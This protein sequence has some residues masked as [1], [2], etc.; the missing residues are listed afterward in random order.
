[1]PP[2][3]LTGYTD[4]LSYRPGAPVE[5]FVSLPHHGAV[6]VELIRPNR[7]IGSVRDGQSDPVVAWPAAGRYPAGPQDSCVGSFMVGA[8]RAAPAG[9]LSFG[10][11]LWLAAIDD[12][13]PATVAEF[14]AGDLFV[15]IELRAGRAVLHGRAAGGQ[16]WALADPV[17]LQPLC[18]YLI[19]GVVDGEQAALTVID[20]RRSTTRAVRASV[21]PGAVPATRSVTYAGSR[22]R[23]V[24]QAG[25]VVRGRVT[26]SLTGK[27]GA[28]FVTGDAV[29]TAELAQLAVGARPR[30]LLAGR[31][32]GA[33]SLAVAG[34]P[35]HHRA[36]A[37][38][39]GIEPALLVNGPA[40]GVTGARWTGRVT[41]YALAPDEYE[42]AHFHAT[43][44]V[45]AGWSA[46]LAARLPES[47]PSG[48][49][50]LR[51]SGDGATD[52][53]PIVVLP[54]PAS[55]PDVLLL[56]PTFS[57]LAYGNE[58]LFEIV[59]GALAAGVPYELASADILHADR[60]FGRSLYDTHP[61]GS[62]VMLSAAAR[63]IVNM[64]PDYTMWQVRAGRG[65]SGDM[66]LIEWLDR[67]GIGYDVITDLELHQGGSA[68]LTGYA[69]VLTGA[70]PEYYS[71]RMLDALTRYRD[72]GGGLMYLGGN[73]FY[74]PTEVLSA[75]PLVVEV[76]RG[77][78]GVRAWESAPG[79]VTLVSDHAPGGLWRHRGRPPQQLC[80]VGFAAQGWDR[81]SPYRRTEQSYDQAVSWIF[82]GVQEDP[83]GDY[84]RVLGGA[85]GDEL[86][87]AD[88]ALGTPP[89]AVVLA[90]SFGH[91]GYYQRSV[92]EVPALTRG[93]HGGDTDPEVRADMVFVPAG[94]GGVFSVGS[95]AWSG[96]L[97]HND[98]VNGVSRITRN[99]LDRFRSAA[100]R[101]EIPV[102]F[103]YVDSRWGQLH[104]A[105]AG[106]GPPLLL[107]HQVPRSW[108]EFRE[109]I[110][111]LAGRYRV[112]AMDML[113]FGASAAGPAGRGIEDLAAAS[114]GLMDALGIGSFAVLGHH[115]GG[116][117]AIEMA[118]A[119]PE[120]VSALIVSST[121]WTDADYRRRNA[122]GPG[123][124]DAERSPDGAHLTHWWAQRRPH[125][126]PDMPYLL[127]RLVRDA[128]APGVD[129]AVAHGMAAAYRMEDRITAVTAP[130]LL[131]GAAADEHTIG[132]QEVLRQRLIA[133]SS[134][135]S[136][137]IDGGTVP[138]MEQCP[139][140]VAAAV[141]AFLTPE[142]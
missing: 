93:Q 7:A 129:P 138:L 127:D 70:H 135:D 113:G 47:L 63:P 84:G 19:A 85:A 8:L 48:L 132:D 81:S 74:W 69:A 131:I 54:Q 141:S 106:A 125:Y 87:R 17:V 11:F 115:T 109:I 89:E 90:S 104:Y 16:V 10:Q 77:H 134:V 99:V 26:N 34:A 111:L 92:E 107:L 23:D 128:L 114:A 31:L 76:R 46:T 112:I 136:V 96:A 61:D 71:E 124:D 14:A 22:P 62:G 118:A 12:Q 30:D 80:G 24:E 64:R 33:W 66:Y 126:P 102:R 51:V 137:V 29:R 119:H 43:D 50:G 117:V 28:P 95:I 110:P 35:D 142:G 75:D 59:D 27:L 94:R 15:G 98:S 37:E 120:R 56:L 58:S 49:Y 103:G 122:D 101:P 36:A 53:I 13:G 3:A 6:D 82:D 38:A 133:A 1:M 105:E 41:D 9:V 88:A 44:L 86:D 73:G 97:L 83:I 57:Y 116:V 42:A 25:G 123:V 100:S 72:A 108:D 139:H 55:S 45:D 32:L 4:R 40:R 5:L 65:L 67:Q 39:P 18:W 140:E 121:P 2:N 91:S 130:V 68:A 20:V 78:S 52:T 60:S 21:P 79:E